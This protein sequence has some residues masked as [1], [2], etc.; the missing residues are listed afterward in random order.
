VESLE[1]QEGGGASHACAGKFVHIRGMQSRALSC[2]AVLTGAAAGIHTDHKSATQVDVVR[3]DHM[4]RSTCHP[5]S[6]E[7]GVTTA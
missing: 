6:A 4:D 3:R 7:G 2:N 5:G 1:C